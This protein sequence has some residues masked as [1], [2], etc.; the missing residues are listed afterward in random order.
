MNIYIIFIKLIIAINVTWQAPF[1]QVARIGERMSN[2][3]E[4]DR[5]RDKQLEAKTTD[6]QW[7]W[8]YIREAEIWTAKHSQRDAC[9]HCSW[10]GMETAGEIR[11]RLFVVHSGRHF[12]KL[13]PGVIR[14]F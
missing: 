3:R 9:R 2:D 11:K 10:C 13:A 1:I 12:W 5:I 8:L 14:E 4:K 7:T 6:R